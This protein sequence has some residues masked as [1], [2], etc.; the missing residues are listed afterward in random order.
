[1]SID[2][3]R[4]LCV[5]AVLGWCSTVATERHLA[6]CYTDANLGFSILEVP[7]TECGCYS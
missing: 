3:Q 2:L 4:V 5:L 1:M 7:T 6:K